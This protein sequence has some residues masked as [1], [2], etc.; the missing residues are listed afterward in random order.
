M[1]AVID[2]PIAPFGSATRAEIPPSCPWLTLPETSDWLNIS[3]INPQ[4]RINLGEDTCTIAIR[5]R[6]V[7]NCARFTACR[8]AL[9]Q[10]YQR[11]GTTTRSCLECR[12]L[13]TVCCTT[14]QCGSIGCRLPNPH[15]TQRHQRA[16]AIC[17]ESSSSLLRPTLRKLLAC[18]RLVTRRKG[19]A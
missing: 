13:Q 8:P 1:P 7:N 3:Q 5:T 19:L 15:S 10:S 17:P 2:S 4:S 18:E 11:I 14:F 9:D 16:R 12:Q 6:P